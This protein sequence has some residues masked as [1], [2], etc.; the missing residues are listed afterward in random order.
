M[1]IDAEPA[2]DKYPEANREEVEKLNKRAFFQSISS[3]PPCS[4]LSRRGLETSKCA[5][6]AERRPTEDGPEKSGCRVLMSWM[7]SGGWARR[8]FG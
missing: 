1:D 2:N 8:S 4:K 6:M 7:F 3:L 5:S